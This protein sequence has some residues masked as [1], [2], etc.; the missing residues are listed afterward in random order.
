ME[1]NEKIKSLVE[2]SVFITI[3][4]IGVYLI[5]I[6]APG[7]YVHIGD[8]M[9]FL[10]V[11]FLGT[12]R[13]ALAGGIGAA[14]S[15]VLGGYAVWILPTFFLK[16]L[17]GLLMGVLIE[18]KMFKLKGRALW[19]GSATI[20][21]TVQIAGYA[22]VTGILYGKAMG[23]ASIP[24]LILQV[25][26]GLAIAIVLSEALSRTSLKNNFAYPIF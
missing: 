5:K 23:I 20:A 9:I 19:I 11:L 21:G 7:G 12:K 6:P 16:A 24:G 18:K 4:F 17:M 13:G 22:L 3:V 25:V 15:D 2:T 10:A 26:V 14:L 8:S 1:R